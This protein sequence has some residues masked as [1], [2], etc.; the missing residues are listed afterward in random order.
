MT[1]SETAT[2]TCQCGCQLRDGQ[3]LEAIAKDIEDQAI[4][5]LAKLQVA[6]AS[7]RATYFVDGM[8]KAASIVR[9]AQE[10]ITKQ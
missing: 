10:A 7:P 3:M 6:G 1:E 2:A 9:G 4:R 5:A 8:T